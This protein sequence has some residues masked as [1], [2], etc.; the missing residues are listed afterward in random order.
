MLI[1]SL[2][3]CYS[4]RAVICLR[5]GHLSLLFRVGDFRKS[6]IVGATLRAW[7]LQHRISRE[8]EVLPHYQHMLPLSVDSGGSVH[9][10]NYL[11]PLLNN[12]DTH[13]I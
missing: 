2:F 6:H 5:D 8:G 4:K 1:P 12:R 13:R 3:V 11:K 10:M 7:L 9:M